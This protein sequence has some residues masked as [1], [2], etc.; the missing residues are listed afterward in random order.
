MVLKHLG[1]SGEQRLES[2]WRESS[3]GG[4]GEER[5]SQIALPACLAAGGNLPPAVLS[6]SGW[7]RCVGDRVSSSVML[8]PLRPCCGR[9]EG[10]NMA[11]LE[12]TELPVK[13]RYSTANDDERRRPRP[14]P[15]AWGRLLIC[16]WPESLTV[17]GSCGLGR[18]GGEEME[19]ICCR[20]WET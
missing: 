6:P 12:P 7:L 20:G 9:G 11:T 4:F 13:M 2:G 17:L 15:R 1:S 19:G 3:G 16:F 8:L 10:G 14:P 18:R 5:V